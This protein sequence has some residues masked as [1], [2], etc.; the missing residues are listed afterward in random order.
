MIRRML[1]IIAVFLVAI[2][3]VAGTWTPNN[4]IYKP[5]LGARGAGEKATFDTGLDRIDA[6]LGKEIWV[7]DP[8]SGT[9]LQSAVTA[10]GSTPTIL[11]VPAGTYSIA[12][13]LT[14]PANITLKAQRGAILSIATGV[15]LTINGGLDAGLYQ[16][17]SWTGTGKVVFGSGAVT[18]VYPE[19]WGARGDNATDNTAALQAAATACGAT[20]VLQLSPGTYCFTSTPS[21]Y[22]LT[23]ACSISGTSPRT[24][25]LKNTG[26]GSALLIQGAVYYSKWENFA[27]VGNASSQDGIVTSNSGSFNYETSYSRFQSVDSHDHGR[28]GLVN[29]MSWGTRYFDCKFYNNGGLGVYSYTAAGDAGTA[30]GVSFFNCESRWN[31]GTGDASADFSK[32]GVRITGAAGFV[33]L[34]GVVES[35]NAWGFIISEQTASSTVQAISVSGVFFE[36]NPR[37]DGS[38]TVGGAVR[39]GG[40]WENVLVENCWI[41]YGAKATATGYSFY[42]TTPAGATPSF[43]ERNNMVLPSGAGTH[44]RDYKSGGIIENNGVVKQNL[45]VNSGFGVW[46][47]S[48]LENVGNQISV[49]GIAAGVCSTADTQGLTVGKLVKFGAG[50]STANKVYEVAAVTANTSFT[51]HDTSI[52]DATPVTCY[53]VT[54]GCIAANDLGPDGW[55]KSYTSTRPTLYREFKGINTKG[56]YAVKVTAT[57]TSQSGGICQ[58]LHKT[59]SAVSANAFQHLLGR[60]L[61]LGCWVKADAAGVAELQFY[62]RLSG[63]AGAITASRTNLT[64]DWDWIEVTRTFP[65]SALDRARVFLVVKT[66][67]HTVYFSQPMLVYGNAIGYGNYAQPDNETIYLETPINLTNFY[68]STV[69][70]SR[71]INLRTES[72]GMLPRGIKAA[73]LRVSVKQSVITDGNFLRVSPNSSSFAGLRIFPQVANISLGGTGWAPTDV[74]TAG[75][76]YAGYGV[77]SGTF[78]STITVD[79]VRLR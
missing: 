56:F 30:N 16:V 60:T 47:N 62:D 13:N 19:W 38:S 76:L 43:I 78:T 73:G 63:G 66:T 1:A 59:D 11:R 55:T 39:L 72:A 15:T 70:T 64:T 31:G 71:T 9:T 40:T 50:G 61:T 24:A 27:V 52:T 48:T 45:L 44:I 36:D 51:L 58:N 10:I 23:V 46:S 57:E 69:T 54:P 49:S 34:G 37:A 2:P 5:S 14:V 3:A 17:F 4:F 77:T 6:R 20:Q 74:N 65:T 26:T 79:A 28:H 22:G 33:W 29:R 18:K 68:G 32:G 42:V 75:D 25:I 53:E 21:N 67:G 35:N 7:G 12:A 8:G 41:S